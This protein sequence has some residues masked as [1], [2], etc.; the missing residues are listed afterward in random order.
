[1]LCGGVEVGIDPVQVEVVFRSERH[2][3]LRGES[4]PG[5]APLSRFWQASD[6]WARTHANYPWHQAAPVA[7]LKVDSVEPEVVAKAVAARHRLRPLPRRPHRLDLTPDELT[8]MP[9]S[10]S[11]GALFTC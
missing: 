1:M 2:L 8:E 5:F 10:R 6:G 4:I 11:R 9:T 3:R 7:A